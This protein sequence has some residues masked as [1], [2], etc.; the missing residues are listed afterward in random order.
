VLSNE[1]FRDN[2]KDQAAFWFYVAQL[3]ARYDANLCLDKSARQAVSVLNNQFGPQINQ[4]AFANLDSLQATVEKV[5]SFVKDNQ[6]AYDHRWIN[7]HGMDAIIEPKNKNL[8]APATQW[9]EIKSKTQ[10]DYSQGFE[11]FLKS[12]KG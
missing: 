1:L 4:Y 8:S 6:E 12:K 5:I 10:E 11:E 9:D 3:R 7:L 2:Q